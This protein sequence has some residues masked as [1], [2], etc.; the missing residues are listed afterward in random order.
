MLAAAGNAAWH[1]IC[2]RSGRCGRSD[3]A[4]A[5][6]AASYALEAALVAVIAGGLGIIAGALAVTGPTGDLLRA[7]NESAPPHLLGAGHLLALGVAVAGAVA[8]AALPALSVARRPVVRALRGAPIAAAR[9]GAVVGRPV[10]LGARL[11]L[12][13]PG[14]L[15]VAGVAVAASVA[16]VLL[17]LTMARFLVAAE[18]DPALL[19]ERYTLLVPDAPGVFDRVLSTPGV[20]AAATRY[21]VAAVDGFDLGEPMQLVAFGPGRASVFPGRPARFGKARSSIRRGRDRGGSCP[22]PRSGARGDARGR[23][24]GWW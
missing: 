7:L 19:G 21:Q 11:A 15:G 14:R 23:P 20:A 12:A 13:R 22:E 10:L 17:M 8:A 1:A 6:C 16:I 18:K 2:R 24:A 4:G 5:R 9:H 3:S